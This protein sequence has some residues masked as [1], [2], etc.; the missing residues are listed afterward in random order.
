M[1][2]VFAGGNQLNDGHDENSLL[3]THYEQNIKIKKQSNRNFEHQD[4]LLFKEFK[5]KQN[6]SKYQTFLDSRKSLP[7]WNKRDDILNI[8]QK[9]QVILISGE[10]GCGKSTQVP[11]YIL[12]NWLSNDDGKHVEVICTQPRRLS[13]IGVAERVASERVERIGSTI[14]YQIRLET[15]VSDSTRLIFCTT[16]ILLMRL[17][18]DPYLNSITHVIVDEVHERSDER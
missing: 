14:G 7:A 18:S 5:N 13:A 4:A 16:G 12:D 17:Q 10:T 15:K 3:P 2:F 1:Y 9:H 11:Q 8:I 6:N